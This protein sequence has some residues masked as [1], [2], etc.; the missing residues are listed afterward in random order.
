MGRQ[1]GEIRVITRLGEVGKITSK[2]PP[3]DGVHRTTLVADPS[4]SVGSMFAP[5]FAR[6]LF[7]GPFSKNI[8]PQLVAGHFPATRLIQPPC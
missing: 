3:P 4:P 5:G 6:G 1:G 8:G 7:L 2:L